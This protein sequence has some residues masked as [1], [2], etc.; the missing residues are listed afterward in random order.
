M[1]SSIPRSGQAGLR[2]SKFTERIGSLRI[3]LEPLA[4]S[5]HVECSVA[6]EHYTCML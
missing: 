3:M 6:A 2:E 1:T 5:Q 4:A